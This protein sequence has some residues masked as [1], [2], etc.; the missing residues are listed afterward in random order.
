[1]PARDHSSD[2]NFAR[3]KA[4]HRWFFQFMTDEEKAAA[5]KLFVEKHLISRVILGGGD[6]LLKT[7]AHF[8]CDRTSEVLR[9]WL[10]SLPIGHDIGSRSGPSFPS[11]A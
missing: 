4:Y 3:A 11:K 2:L 8:L 5:S 10:R 7:A 6:R 1:M 9:E